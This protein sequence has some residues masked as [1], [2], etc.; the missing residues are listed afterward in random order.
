DLIYGTPG[1]RD[2]DWIRSLR[3]ALS[4]RPD[5]ISGYALIVEE[6][7]RLAA[8][9]RRGE[10]PAPDDDAMADRYLAAD[11][12]LAAAGLR[13]YEISNWAASPAA[14]CRHNLLY[15]TGGGWWGVG[16]GA[17]RHLC[18][19]R[20]WDGRRPAPDAPPPPAAARP[21]HA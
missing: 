4:A 2:A 8:R 10:L 13:W 18:G 3:S 1:E 11:E 14:M 15:W 21:P 17:H 7:T 16:P 19:A 6:G 9:I 12:L 5:H 20:G